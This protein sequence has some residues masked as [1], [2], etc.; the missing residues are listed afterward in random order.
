[1]LAIADVGRAEHWT[2]EGLAAL[3]RADDDRTRRWA[4]ALHN[5]LAWSLHDANRLDEA[6]EEFSLA[7]DAAGRFGGDDQR[8][9]ARWAYARCLR[10][11]GRVPEALAIQ[12][13]LAVER[14]ADESVAEELKILTAMPG[15]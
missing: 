13:E 14:P 12:R 10:S 9:F 11:L 1:M 2:R 3:E 7:L 15:G 6:L 5:N 4:V 8:Y